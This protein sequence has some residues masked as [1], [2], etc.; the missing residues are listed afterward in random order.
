[1]RTV[2]R[3]RPPRPGVS[4]LT[5]C[6][7]AAIVLLVGCSDSDVNQGDLNL[8]GLEAEWQ[9]GQDL[10]A[11]I[12]QQV[13]LVEDPVLLAFVDRIGQDL[14]AQTE[15][16]N[17]P[18]NFHVVRD[19]A[20]N[21]FALPGGHIY[22]HTGLLEAVTSEAE[23]AGVLAHEVSHVEARHNTEMLT[24]A[25]GI[26]VLLDLVTDGEGELER[27]AVDVLGRGAVAKFSR[28]AE[29]EADALGIRRLAAAGY[30][31]EG[32]SSFFGVLLQRQ[33]QQPS[34]VEQFFST[35]P[36]TQERFERARRLGQ[37]LEPSPPLEATDGSALAEVQRR[38]AA[39]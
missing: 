14:A 39:S 37:D 10:H 24:R 26:D 2:D 7:L 31:P 9:L 27:V 20:L 11:E 32:M 35:H 3:T 33:Q 25:Y 13:E 8:F 15:L 12:S 6:L 21:A 34:V 19:P 38:L 23:V 5:A 4:R 28:N 1:M 36:L 17:W 18:W 22:L 30:E 16:A 29:R